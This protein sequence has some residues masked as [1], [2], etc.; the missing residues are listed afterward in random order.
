MSLDPAIM[1]QRMRWMVA[2]NA[3][4]AVVG[5][6]SAVGYFKLGVQWGLMAFG[7]AML[8]GFGAQIWFIVGLRRANKG[9]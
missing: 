3:A 1:K 6:V 2:I 7:V 8:A 5:L 4:A 9:A